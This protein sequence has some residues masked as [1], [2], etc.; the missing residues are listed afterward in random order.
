MKLILKLLVT[1]IS[2]SAVV[3]AQHAVVLNS[4]DATVSIIDIAAG[5]VIATEPT[6]KEPHHLFPSVDGK[7]LWVAN[8]QSDDLMEID[9]RSGKLLQ[10]IKNIPDPYQLGFSDDGKWFIS[11]ALR[12][13]RVDLYRH[14]TTAQGDTFKLVKRIPTGSMPSHT[15]FSADNKTA[16]VSLQGD[17]ELIAIDLASQ[18]ISWK[19]PLGKTPAG[20]W[21]TPQG[22]VL[23]GIMGENYVQVVDPAQRTTVKKIITAHGAH[24]FRGR[25]DGKTVF[26]SNRDSKTISA[27]DMASL[28]KLY[29]IPTLSGPDCMD[30]SADGKTLW[31]TNRWVRKVSMIDIESRKTLQSIPV[32]SSPHGV[33]LTQRAAF[34]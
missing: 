15:V 5:K 18:T 33:F 9:P 24:A 22:M 14:Q 28:T 1:F 12:L 25:G 7:K 26:V 17:N 31:V 11:I 8:A 34:K 21:L 20:L 29:D 16:Y 4:R 2:F 30:V 13:D 6:G 10:R 23:V 27:I 19:T 32:G 3:Q